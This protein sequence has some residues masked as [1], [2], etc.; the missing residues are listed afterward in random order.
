MLS[1]EKTRYIVEFFI[2][3]ESEKSISIIASANYGRV[4]RVSAEQ[5][6][7]YLQAGGIY[8]MFPIIA[9]GPC[10][11]NYISLDLPPSPDSRSPILLSFVS[12]GA[13]RG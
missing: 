8:G 2:I 1:I 9:Y 4:N 5:S 12:L 6:V 7:I 3:R 11:I 10:K 13:L